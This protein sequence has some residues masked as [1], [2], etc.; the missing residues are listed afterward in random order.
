MTSGAAFRISFLILLLIISATLP[1]HAQWQRLET[2]EGFLARDFAAS[3]H[4]NFALLGATD[5]GLYVS[6]DRGGNWIHRADLDSLT[7][8][9]LDAHGNDIFLLAGST[10]NA[11]GKRRVYRLPA[12]DAAVVPVPAPR[13]G[14][15]SAFCI[16]DNGWMYATLEG[17][18]ATD[19]V[20]YST[21]AGNSWT[22]VCRKYSDRSGKYA[23]RI[24]PLRRIWS[25]DQW[26]LSRWDA[27]TQQWLRWDG[28]G[29]TSGSSCW[30]FFRPNGDLVACT[31]ARIDL[32]PASGAAVTTL[33]QST[34]TA[35]PTI[36]FW[37]DRDGALLVSD[38][39]GDG[40]LYTQVFR[41]TSDEGQSWVVVDSSRNAYMQFL[42][43]SDGTVF[44]GSGESVLTTADLG[45]TFKNRNAGLSAVNV[46]DFEIRGEHIH[47]LTRSYAL[48]DD[49]GATWQY[50]DTESST[51][52]PALQVLSDGTFLCIVNGYLHMSRDSAATWFSAQPEQQENLIQ[53]VIATDDVM[54]GVF[55]DNSIRRSTD[56]GMTWMS[57]HL[58]P[59][60]PNSLFEAH[61]VFY[62]MY[63]DQLLRSTDRGGTW[64]SST[65]PA[66]ERAFL[67]GNTR[68]LFLSA[69]S[70]LWRSLDHGDTWN[71]LPLDTLT[72]TFYGIAHN[73][74]GDIAAVRMASDARPRLTDIVYS[75]NDGE[76]WKKI[77]YDLPATFTYGGFP[78]GVGIGFT[79]SNTLFLSVPSRGFYTLDANTL[80]TRNAPPSSPALS[81][82]VWPTVADDEV[83]VTVRFP[84]PVR[85]RVTSL[86]GATMYDET[87][88]VAGQPRR[89][90]V[91]SWPAGMY[92]LHA[93]SGDSRTAR[94]FMILR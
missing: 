40:G 25:Y 33:Y 53:Q 48:S 17:N 82:D 58:I 93:Q 4:G 26:S 20:Y 56:G 91:G 60:R 7:I 2:L 86:L 49:G 27:E 36:E 6:T 92:L 88:P 54:V 11:R 76:S 64:T 15:V 24:D 90:D 37:M 69:S 85:L 30:Y 52:L 14:S 50:R 39:V 80:G 84:R 70:I 81:L 13:D 10:T 62:T 34:F 71:P 73:T 19:S 87:L 43:E 9:W 35:Y 66:I 55:Y 21:D 8:N 74:R 51:S 31:G 41:S 12:I 29:K 23:L 77:T 1:A 44:A 63:D 67:F 46:Q 5:D 89:L 57:A 78:F 3:E 65:L 59:G 94:R 22:S 42:G 83:Q 32:L 79:A 28:Y 72:R 38:R 16:A 61:G 68:A 18:P 75:A 47:A 45:R